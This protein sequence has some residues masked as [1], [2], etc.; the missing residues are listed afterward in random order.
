[1]VQIDDGLGVFVNIAELRKVGGPK[2]SLETIDVT[3]HNTATPWRRFIGGLLNAGEVT[4]ELNFIP[5]ETTHSYSAGLIRDMVNRTQR[6]F[7][8][9]FPD[10]GT[11]TW[12]FTGL[13]T[14]FEMSSDPAAVL[15]ANVTI[16][17]SEPP[18]LAG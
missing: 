6:H 9:I 16:K 18:T 1:M 7:K 11:T 14:N 2:L 8:I 13:V 15:Q 10:A 17:V 5:T 12:A 3:V 4:M